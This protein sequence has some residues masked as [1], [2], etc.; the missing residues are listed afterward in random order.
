M[1]VASEKTQEKDKKPKKVEVTV[2]FPLAGQGP[3]KEKMDRDTTAEQVRGEAMAHFGVADSPT[4]SYY[5]AHGR[6][7]LTGSETVGDLAEDERELK[8]KL[9]KELVQG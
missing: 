4:D 3:H 5:L 2:A 1:P 7:R 9:V 8:L 6:K